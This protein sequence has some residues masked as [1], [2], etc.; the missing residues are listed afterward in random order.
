M[1][2]IPILLLSLLVFTAHADEKNYNAAIGLI[3]Q[4]NYSAAKILLE[5]EAKDEA[6]SPK[7]CYALGFCLEKLKDK[8]AVIWYKKAVATNRA[9]S[10]D[11]DDAEKAMKRLAELD[12]DALFLLNAADRLGDMSK[13]ARKNSTKAA[14]QRSAAELE[15]A[16]LGA[17]VPVKKGREPDAANK[18]LTEAE[19]EKNLGY[20][21]GWAPRDAVKGP[22][23]H[24][25][26]YFADKVTWEE[27][28]ARCKKMGGYLVTIAT[29]EENKFVAQLVG[30]QETWIGLSDVAKEGAWKWV[31]SEP[32]A[33]QAW[34]KREPNGGR[35]ENYGTLTK[36]SR[37]A[38]SI[39]WNDVG[40]PRGYI[41]E[42]FK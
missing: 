37:R 14:F 15:E 5:A 18:P 8:S 29:A 25:Y 41:C 1:R 13:R 40:T 36:G 10:K 9:S 30:A 35:R 33:Y 7:L 32:L 16:A 31:T 3:K 34:N 22:D 11:P 27:A 4:K 39:L 26:E 21:L 2:T 19:L 17:S 42:W 12:P 38:P 28:Q 24:K 23:G 6:P 20:N